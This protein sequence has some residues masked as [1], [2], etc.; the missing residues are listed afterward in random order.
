MIFVEALIIK[1]T[2]SYRYSSLMRCD[3]LRVG[4]IEGHECGFLDVLL[5]VEFYTE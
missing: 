1:L 2:S 3:G 4:A 5:M